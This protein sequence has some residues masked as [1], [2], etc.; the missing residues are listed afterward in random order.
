MPE[1]GLSRH[2]PAGITD[3]PV[4]VAAEHTRGSTTM[5]ELYCRISPQ[6]DLFVRHVRPADSSGSGQ[7]VCLLHGAGMDSLG[8]DVGV[9]GYSLMD[10]LAALGHDVFTYDYRGH[11]R[12]SRVPDG[13]AVTAEV[14]RDDTL[15]LL[16]ALGLGSGSQRIHLVGESFG[17]IVAPLV[18]KGLGERCGSMTLLGSIFASLGGMTDSF[19][20]FLAEMAQAPCGYAYTTEEEWS[21]LFIGNADRAVVRWHQVYFGTAYMYPVGPYQSVGALPVDQDLGSVT[22]P[23]RVVI[24]DR[25]PFATRADMELL[26]SA[27]GSADVDITVQDGIGHLPY[28]EVRSDEVVEVLDDAIRAGS[29]SPDRGRS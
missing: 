12:S 4:R 26:L 1:S 5:R 2:G 3:L 27:L 6:L 7:Q 28:V 9:P 23:T 16:D 25:D 17:S 19:P 24:G 20:D 29:T 22:C 13:R 14:V 10:R 15:A 18:A 21:D 11:G 8:F